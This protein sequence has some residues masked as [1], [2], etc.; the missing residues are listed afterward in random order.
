MPLW[1][2]FEYNHANDHL[3][4]NP[5]RPLSRD[6]INTLLRAG[7]T[8][9]GPEGQFYTRWS[10]QVVANLWEIPSGSTIV[11]IDDPHRYP[12][13]WIRSDDDR[14]ILRDLQL[15]RDEVTSGRAPL[16]PSDRGMWLA[17]LDERIRYFSR[18]AR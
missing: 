12:M 1:G 13:E 5:S 10:P 18:R 14:E 17:H 15:Q 6:A 16:G 11:E 2:R 4:F 7:F 8:Q 3:Y 9:D